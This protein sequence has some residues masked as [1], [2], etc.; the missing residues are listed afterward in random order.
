MMSDAVTV[1]P[2]LL[3]RNTT[4]FTFLS[5]AARLSCSLMV[6]TMLGR[7]IKPSESAELMTP[8]RSTSSTF[9]LPLPLNSSSFIGPGGGGRLIVIQPDIV[10]ANDIDSA[11]NNHRLRMRLLHHLSE[12]LEHIRRVVRAWRSFRVILDRKSTRL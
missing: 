4:A 5:S 12:L 2:G 11:P 8:D 3:M 9:W 1:P 10:K 7:S 6:A